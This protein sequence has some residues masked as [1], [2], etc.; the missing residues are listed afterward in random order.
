MIPV[1]KA[2]VKAITIGVPVKIK[3]HPATAE[4]ARPPQ[5]PSRPPANPP[6][7]QL[8]VKKMFTIVYYHI[9]EI[10]TFRLS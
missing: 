9:I 3:R 2:P 10:F 4:I 1:R 8:S 6:I 7:K 5:M